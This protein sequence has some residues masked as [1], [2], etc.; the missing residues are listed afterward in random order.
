[1]DRPAE[2]TVD[3]LGD[4]ARCCLRRDVLRSGAAVSSITLLLTMR[5]DTSAPDGASSAERGSP[6][7]SG[8]DRPDAGLAQ[9]SAG[10]TGADA[11]GNPNASA[12]DGA[13]DQRRG[14]DGDHDADDRASDSTTEGGT[15][16]DGGNDRGDEQAGEDDEDGTEDGR[17]NGGDDG[18]DGESD[19]PGNDDDG[20]GEDDGGND[21]GG[22]T[23]EDGGDGTDD[24]DDGSG[25][26]GDDG[27]G[28]EGTDDPDWRDGAVELSETS[29]GASGAVDPGSRCVLHPKFLAAHELEV[30]RQIRVRPDDPGAVADAT[31]TIVE[32]REGD[33]FDL[34]LDPSGLDRLDATGG[35]AA[36]IDVLA[37]DP[38]IESRDGA[39]ANAEYAEVLRGTKTQ[40]RLVVLAPH[41][42]H[43]E[44]GTD[45]QAERLA[46]ALDGLAWIAAGYDDS[47]IAFDRFHVTST[48]IHPDSFPTL[49]SIAK[50][51]F[52]WGVA[53]HGFSVDDRVLVGGRC[54]ESV[55]AGVRDAIDEVLPETAVEIAPP[56]GPYAG[57][58]PD[59]VLNRL[60]PF[61]RTIQLEQ[62]LSIRREAA[63]RVVDAV[64]DALA[65]E[66]E[67]T[68][69]ADRRSAF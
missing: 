15:E 32:S 36:A 13:A 31:F 68:S 48:A 9:R 20:D 19:G 61:D 28:D 8:G 52:E 12:G 14:A 50:T 62:P 7:A 38:A 4:A 47:G 10:G 29:L 64:A 65:D 34:G 54:D 3:R 53:F 59:N 11:A 60:A 56:D 67:G 63:G 46:E 45:R 6:A 44:P 16:A 26:D 25:D 57:T 33:P 23:G 30:G 18:G 43:V 21:D 27:S 40:Q 37:V 2:R 24:G 17:E 58:S 42:G 39:L 69:I 49:R 1:M 35:D 41:G 22:D 66:L 5:G 51:D 55:K